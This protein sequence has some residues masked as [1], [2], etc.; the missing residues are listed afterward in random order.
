MATKDDPKAIRRKGSTPNGG[1]ASVARYVDVHGETVVKSKA[2]GIKI[3]ELDSEGETIFRTYAQTGRPTGERFVGL[4]RVSTEQ[5]GESGLGLEAGLADLLTYADS[6][7]GGIIEVFTEVESGTHDEIIDRPTLL[8]ALALAKRRKATLLIPK[9]DRL[10]R[11]T[12]VHTD[13]KRSGVPFRAVD[14]PH[15]NEFTLDILVAVAAQE[16]RAI[17]AR[18]KAALAAYKATARVSKRIR[19]MYPD[20]VP[21]AVVK[22]TAGKLGA[23]LPQCRNLTAE[24]RAKGRAKG[25]AKLIREA[26]EVY[27]DLVPGIEAAKAEGLSLRAVADRLNEQGH[28]TRT[29]KPWSAVQVMRVLNRAGK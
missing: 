3:D 6:V 28:T 24:A 13:I 22:A 26:R 12:S 23:S 27:A 14:N 8:K 11:S 2:V 4:V 10:V 18:T 21:Q 25:R 20:G 19:L 7:G 15:A 5:Q 16:A 9:V 29:G 1:S 17:S